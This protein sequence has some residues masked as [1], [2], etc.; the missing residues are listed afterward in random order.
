MPSFKKITSKTGQ[1]TLNTT[2]EYFF[3]RERVIRAITKKEKQAFSK[4]GAWIRTTMQSDMRESTKPNPHS[5]ADESPRY[6]QKLL[7]SMINFSYSPLRHTVVI[8]PEL[9]ATNPSI[10]PIG[11]TVPELLNDGGYALAP[12]HYVL[13][14]RQTGRIISLASRAAR[15][16]LKSQSYKK[17]KGKKTA[18]YHLMKMKAGPKKFDARNFKQRAYQ[19]NITKPKLQAA[20]SVIN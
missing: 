10:K 11:K 5:K 4:I 17:N 12:E 18:R 2:I 19:K 14:D 3:D 1:S 9:I 13:K 8:G 16:V 15:L 6:S 20:W 7:R